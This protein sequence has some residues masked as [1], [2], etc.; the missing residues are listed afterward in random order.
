MILTF[1]VYQQ[2]S[3]KET[4]ES[5]RRRETDSSRLRTKKYQTDTTHQHVRKTVS[6][7]TV[8]KWLHVSELCLCELY[9][10]EM[11]LSE[12]YLNEL[13]LSKQYLSEMYLSE[14]Y[15]SKLYLSDLY[16]SELYLSYLYLSKLCLSQLTVTCIF[17][18]SRNWNRAQ[19][20]KWEHSLYKKFAF[21]SCASHQSLT[22]DHASW[23]IRRECGSCV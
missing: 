17:R 9:L 2:Q 23:R 10:S 18:L 20:P 3:P 11:N 8:Y 16:L 19:H 22:E 14:L 1:A 6:K 21:R 15:L 4:S 13:Y 12:L 7:W 5:Q